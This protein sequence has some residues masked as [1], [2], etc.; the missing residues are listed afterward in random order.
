MTEHLW[1]CA[2]LVAQSSSFAMPVGMMGGRGLNRF[3]H[4]SLFFFFY[5]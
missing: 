1:R 2:F 4:F 5:Q 3:H